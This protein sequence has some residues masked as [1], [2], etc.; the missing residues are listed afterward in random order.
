MKKITTLCFL[1]AFSVISAQI[2]YDLTV[3]NEAYVNLEDSTPL[4]N[5]EVWDDPGYVVPLGF[6]FQIGSLTVDTV[7]ISD[8]GLG[9]LVAT[10]PTIDGPEVGLFAPILQD[11]IDRGDGSSTSLSPVSFR[12]DGSVGNRILKLEWNN[13]GFFDNSDLQDFVN[14]Q[15]WLYESGNVI[16][17]RYG[18]SMINSPNES[19]EGLSGLQIALIPLLPN[20]DV[21]GNLEQEAYILSGDP[22]NPD[23]I[24]LSTSDDF[25][26]AESIAITGAVP[27]GTVYRFSSEQLSLEDESIIEV[28]VYPN[29]TTDFFKIE[30]ALA[31]YSVHIYNAAGQQIS[32]VFAPMGLYDVSN[33][34]KGVYFVKVFSDTGVTTKRLIKI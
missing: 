29:P 3:L 11:I 17:Y 1:L 8:D 34:S 18:P 21:E 9:G 5:G 4:S 13:T 6:D 22:L 12:I 2:E 19:F 25:D 7:F 27:E 28:N 31:S 10:N 16:E 14:F 15:L 32:E 23:L 24:V 33:L 30:S 20:D 26:N